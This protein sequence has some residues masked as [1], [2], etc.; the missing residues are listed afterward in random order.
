[1]FSY[2]KKESEVDDKAFITGAFREHLTSKQKHI[3]GPEY[4]IYTYITYY[5]VFC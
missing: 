4:I 5:I 3:N 1:M 2:Y